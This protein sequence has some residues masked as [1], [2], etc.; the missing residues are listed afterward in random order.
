M[1]F[2]FSN[3]S[4]DSFFFSFFTLLNLIG[5]NDTLGDWGI[6]ESVFFVSFFGT[7]DRDIDGFEDTD[8]LG[9]TKDTDFLG[10]ALTDGA[11]DKDT[12]GEIKDTDFLGSTFFLSSTFFFGS[13]LTDGAG[14]KD[15]FEVNLGE[16]GDKDIGDNDGFEVNLGETGDKDGFEVNLGE[17]GDNDFFAFFFSVFLDLYTSPRIEL[18]DLDLCIPLGDSSDFLE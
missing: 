3:F 1:Y 17:T 15:T 11:R 4:N 16:T 5:D 9:D 8:I 13:A 10:S 7:T 2:S 18:F 12:F 6:D 14:D